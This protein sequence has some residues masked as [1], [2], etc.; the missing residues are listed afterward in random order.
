MNGSKNNGHD[1]LGTC[2]LRVALQG[3][4][5]NNNNVDEFSTLIIGSGGKPFTS[6]R[7]TDKWVVYFGYG[8]VVLFNYEQVLVNTLINTPHDS[9]AKFLRC[10]TMKNKW[11]WFRETI[12]REFEKLNFDVKKKGSR[13]ALFGRENEQTKMLFKIVASNNSPM[14]DLESKLRVIDRMKSGDPAW[15][16]ARHHGMCK[17]L[18]EEFKL[19]E[20]LLNLNFK[21]EFIQ[22]NTKFFLE[23]LDSRKGERIEWYIVIL[24]SEELGI[25]VYELLMELAWIE[26]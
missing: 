11:C 23:V 21:L 24:I 26:K 10:V 14:I 5:S 2:N 6:S 9:V 4:G 17:S 19:N 16:Q 25:G 22:H 13:C 3:S 18:L 8:A 1:G 7:G 15:I 12:L 20:R